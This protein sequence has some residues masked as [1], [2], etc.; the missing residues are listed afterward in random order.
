MRA[1]L[2]DFYAAASA[3][4]IDAVAALCTDDVEMRIPFQIP[5]FPSHA[6]G[7]EA[8]LQGRATMEL[9]DSYTQW[10]VSMEQLLDADSWLVEARGDML[11]R[12]TGLPYRNDYHSLFRFRDGKIAQWITYHDPIRHLLAFGITDLSRLAP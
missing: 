9:Y 12:E 6:T 7:K 10:V 11:V 5:G 4:D 8:L 3:K 2:E 1:T